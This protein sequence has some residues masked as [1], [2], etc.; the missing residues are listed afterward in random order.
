[1]PTPRRQRRDKPDEADAEHRYDSREEE[2]A[3]PEAEQ[4]KPTEKEQQDKNRRLSA[5]LAYEYGSPW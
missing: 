4:A 1:M 5:Q 2:R 3:P